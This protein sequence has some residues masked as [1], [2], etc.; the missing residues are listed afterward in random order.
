M[1]VGRSLPEPSDEAAVP[2]ASAVEELPRGRLQETAASV[3][4]WIS[5]FEDKSCPEC[6]CWPHQGDHF[7]GC[8]HRTTIRGVSA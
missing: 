1:E 8:S 4:K 2:G 7:A 3:V 5:P 6:G